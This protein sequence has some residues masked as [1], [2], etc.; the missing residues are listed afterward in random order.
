MIILVFIHY[1]FWVKIITCLWE[2]FQS[3]RVPNFSKLNFIWGQYG[4]LVVFKKRLK[5]VAHMNLYFD[6]IKTPE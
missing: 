6:F 4:R 1:N 3:K 5:L 2:I